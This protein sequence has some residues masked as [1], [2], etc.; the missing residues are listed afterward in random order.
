MKGKEKGRKKQREGG[1]GG[2][3]RILRST[4]TYHLP[5]ILWYMQVLQYCHSSCL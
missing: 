1:R 3:E 2:R 5:G 4:C